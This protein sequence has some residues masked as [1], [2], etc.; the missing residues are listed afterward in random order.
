MKLVFKT[1]HLSIEIGC[2]EP[3]KVGL[4]IGPVLLWSGHYSKI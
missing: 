4:D 2:L 3:K 1:R